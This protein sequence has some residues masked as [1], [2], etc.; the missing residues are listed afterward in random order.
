[1]H[2]EAIARLNLQVRVEGTG[3][4]PFGSMVHRDQADAFVSSSR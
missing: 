1:V 2:R 4:L 3:W